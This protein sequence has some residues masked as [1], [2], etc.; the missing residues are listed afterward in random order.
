MW[1]RSVV[2]LLPLVS[3]C[4]LSYALQRLRTAFLALKR[5]AAPG[6][7]G[8][9]WQTYEADLDRKIEDLHA[10]TRPDARRDTLPTAAPG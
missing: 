2:S 5:D 3:P 7:D 9:T 4:G 10:R 8:L 1:W 6:V